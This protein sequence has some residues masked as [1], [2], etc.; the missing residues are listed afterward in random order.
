MSHQSTVINV[1]IASPSSANKER[2]ICQKV[3]DKWNNLN[4]N[5]RQMFLKPERWENAYPSS[6][7]PQD[8]I[9]KQCLNKSDLLIGIF[10]DSFG[11][12][13]DAGKCFTE[14][15]IDYH[16]QQG[17]PVMVFFS[18]MPPENDPKMMT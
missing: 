6:D 12:K 10:R 3:L 4:S 15:E 1:F 9:N 11:R 14:G 13:D 7:K 18:D 8:A 17:K 2:D 16:I 5:F